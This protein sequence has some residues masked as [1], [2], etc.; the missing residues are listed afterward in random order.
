MLDFTTRKKKKY[1]VKLHDSF[2]AILP[3]PNKEM[4][5]KMVAAQEMSDIGEV[6]SLLTAIIN[7]NKKRRY[8][9]QKIEDMF[10]FADAV[11]LLKDYLG[12]VKDVVTDPN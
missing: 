2:V 4:F 9:Q 7:Q 11:E 6:Y 1:M 10:D 8:S 12:S 3:M 5:D